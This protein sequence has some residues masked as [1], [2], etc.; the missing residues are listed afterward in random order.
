MTV[1]S[2]FSSNLNPE[3]G[4]RVSHILGRLHVNGGQAPRA[5]ALDV[6]GEIVEEHNA[7]SRYAD[8]LHH[9]IIGRRIRF[10]KPD[11]GRQKDFA[12]MAEHAGIDYREML[13]MGAIGVEERIK[14]HAPGG[15][16]EQRLDAGHFARED[17]VP[18]LKELGIGDANAHRRPEALK[19][20]GVTDLA[21]LVA[22]IDFVTRKSP[23]QLRYLAACVTGPAS[24]GLVEIDIEHHAAEIEQQRVG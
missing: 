8:R 12:E 24:Q 7:W 3:R 23:G 21:L 18:P 4:K 13:D 19:E 2:I 5:C 9:M 15:A 20:F 22:P 11:R 1:S 16:L 17:R 14:R 6:L 10:P